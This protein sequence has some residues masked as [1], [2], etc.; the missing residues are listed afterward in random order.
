VIA[1]PCSASIRGMDPYL[2]T[3][4]GG[5]AW[6]VYDFHVV[7]DRRRALPINDH[8]AERR[9]F[10]AVEGGQVLVY[11]FLPVSYH[12]TEPKLIADQLRIAKP[13]DAT[14]GERPNGGR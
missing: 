9:A 12:S 7:R 1:I 4:T 13:I 11:E 10:V 14:A 3:D 5:R 8:R 6:H 2:F